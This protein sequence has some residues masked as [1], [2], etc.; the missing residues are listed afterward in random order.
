MT[1]TALD[2]CNSAE[3]KMSGMSGSGGGE[4]WWWWWGGGGGE[5]GVWLMFVFYS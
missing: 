3:G 5:E 1:A 4:G 2:I